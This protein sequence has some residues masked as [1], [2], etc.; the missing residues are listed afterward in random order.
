MVLNKVRE[1]KEKV[2][3]LKEKVL[4]NG[5]K[6]MALETELKNDGD[7]SYKELLHVSQS[8]RLKRVASK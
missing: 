3:I 4:G 2:S 7:P 6:E 1:P 5:E 8:K